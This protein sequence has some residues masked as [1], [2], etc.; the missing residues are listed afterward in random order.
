M[1][2]EKACKVGGRLFSWF[3]G[4]LSEEFY[5]YLNFS[6]LDV[7]VQ[8]ARALTYG[9]AIVLSIFLSFLTILAFVLGYAWSYI[10]LASIFIPIIV[11]HYLGNYP[12]IYSEN[13][14]VKALITMPESISY[15]AIS[16]KTVPN[17]EKAVEFAAHKTRGQMGIEF[18]KMLWNTHMRVYNDL[19]EAL[20]VSGEKWKRWNRDFTNS[21]YLMKSSLLERSED[22]RQRMVDRAVD[23][24]IEGTLEKMDTFSRKLSIPTL[25]LYFVGMILPLVMI[26]VL[27]ALSYVGAS[28][29]VNSMFLAYDI[30]IP[31][32]VYLWAR[33]ILSKRPI[34]SLPLN[35][36]MP[37]LNYGNNKVTNKILRK[38]IILLT[39]A[40]ISLV[41]VYLIFISGNLEA[42]TAG[43]N[44]TIFI[45]WGLVLS[46]ST[47]LIATNYHLNKLREET[48]SL[49]ED[50]IEAL[51]QLESRVSDGRPIEDAF[52]KVGEVMKGSKI[53]DIFKKTSDNI[54][55]SRKNL[56]SSLFEEEGS[57]SDV[58]SVAI[59][60]ALE[61]IA[62]SVDKGNQALI[63]VI[64]RNREHLF[65]L[66]EL[67]KR[68]ESKLDDVISSLRSTVIF[69]GP[70][71]AGVIVTIQKMMNSKLSEI[72]AGKFPQIEE[73]SI[74]FGTNLGLTKL[75]ITTIP[76][77]ILQLIIGLYLIEMV[78]IFSI[79]MSELLAG[80]DSILKKMETGKNL[81]IAVILFTSAIWISQLFLQ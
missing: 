7:D 45:I 44:P 39:P 29:G 48:K 13:I 57:L 80:N 55:L 49:E 32:I 34:T 50:F 78:I 79:F 36:T 14:K 35:I 31:L 51:T 19:D 12:R 47:Y 9:S 15:M 40:L 43:F 81:I 1:W 27:P 21:I 59:R 74:P 23:L 68:I 2:Y 17:L 52:F 42:S 75:G 65:K 60:D 20:T 11:L 3:K 22:K 24:I 54:L 46:I 69:F 4:D 76:T 38:K 70:L 61:M 64:S 62:D 5:E 33:K 18:K 8:D 41:S 66:K 53:G 6:N 67:D 30:F 77:G 73:S 63:E 10:L 71:M 16:L 58:Y 56:Y 28:I 25:S 72:N 26:A 37:C